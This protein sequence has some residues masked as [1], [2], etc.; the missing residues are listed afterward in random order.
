VFGNLHGKYVATPNLNI[1]RLVGIKERN[2]LPL[3]LHGGSNPSTPT[4][5]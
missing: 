2:K 3:V 4:S 5:K 1:K